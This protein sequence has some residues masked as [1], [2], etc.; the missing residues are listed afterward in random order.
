M[1]YVSG[2]ESGSGALGDLKTKKRGERRVF[3]AGTSCAGGKAVPPRESE[4]T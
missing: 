3:C 1:T 4:I 2:V